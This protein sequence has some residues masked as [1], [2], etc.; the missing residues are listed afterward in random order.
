MKKII[1]MIGLFLGLLNPSYIDSSCNSSFC[2]DI[3]G[4]CWDYIIVGG[5]TAGAELA[6]GLSGSG[7][8]VLVLEAGINHN[9]DPIT[10]TATGPNLIAD[11]NTI[12]FNPLYAFTYA[13]N[14]FN[15]LEYTVYSEGTGWGGGSAHNYLE[16]VR[17]TPTIYNNWATLSGNNNLAYNNILPILKATENYT[18]CQTTANTAQR[19]VG[20]PISVTQ[21]LPVTSDPLALILATPTNAGFNPDINDPT[22]VSTTGHLNLGF[23]AYQFFA[24]ANGPCNIGQ[25]SF[26][27]NAFFGPN[28]VNQQNGKGVCGR[29]LRVESNAYVSRVCFSGCK[30][31]GVEFVFGCRADKVLTAKGKNIILCAGSVNS[32][33]ILQRSGIGDPALLQPLGIKVLVNNPNVGANLANQYGASAIIVGTTTAQPFLQGFT[34]ASGV[35]T[36]PFSYPNDNTRRIQLLATQITPTLVELIAF[37]LDP[38]SRGSVKIV[39][40]NPLVKPLVDL[41]MYSDGPVTTNG[42]DANLIVSTYML[43]GQIFDGAVIYPSAGQFAGGPEGLLLAAQNLAGLTIA[44]H[45]SATC[46]M[47]TSMETG[48]VDGNFNVFGVENLKVVD[49]SVMPE[50]IDGNICY[51]VYALAGAALQ[52]LGIS[53]PAGA[54]AA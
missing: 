25:R 15:P 3:E 21:G 39:S 8:K 35:A 37:I 45:I 27:G 16:V 44:D 52:T 5:G 13:I 33:A 26:S 46:V 1:L 4:I 24:T 28:S 11:L 53:V 23:S 47:S 32:P 49:A 18:A 20:G 19:G 9:N 41:N 34:N 6:N 7:C 40:T 29:L 22:S 54:P 38:N 31:T 2:C 43:I 36:A 12:T 42:T 48:V 50:L 17:G 30:A 10:L 14:V 51:G